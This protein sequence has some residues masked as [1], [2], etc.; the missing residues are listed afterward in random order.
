VTSRHQQQ[1]AALWHMM[2]PQK[3]F[4]SIENEKQRK[5]IQFAKESEKYFLKDIGEQYATR[6]F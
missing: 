6:Y 1:A 2:Y 3:N 4:Y 5:W